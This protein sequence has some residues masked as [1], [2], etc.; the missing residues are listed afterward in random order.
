ML[1]ETLTNIIKFLIPSGLVILGFYVNH[2]TALSREKRKEQRVLLDTIIK[3]TVSIRDLSIKLHCEKEWDEPQAEDTIHRLT[4]LSLMI[5]RSCMYRLAQKPEAFNRQAITKTYLDYKRAIL[6]KN[7][8][9]VDFQTS[10][11]NSQTTLEITRTAIKLEN[12]LE[13]ALLKHYP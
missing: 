4:R 13:N 3:E 12:L 11:P 1:C 5:Q 10:L 9:A 7:F 6:N 8:S 2:H